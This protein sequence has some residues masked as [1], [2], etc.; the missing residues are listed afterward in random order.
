VSGKG[1]TTHREFVMV[2]GEMSEDESR[3]FGAKR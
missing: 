1:K 2:A 3:I